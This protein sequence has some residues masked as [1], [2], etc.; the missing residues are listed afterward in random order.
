MVQREEVDERAAV[1]R[2]GRLKHTDLLFPVQLPGRGNGYNSLIV[3][4][5]VNDSSRVLLQIPPHR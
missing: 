4:E 2:G 3:L 5:R 1:R